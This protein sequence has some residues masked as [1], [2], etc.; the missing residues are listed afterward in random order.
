M[1]SIKIIVLLLLVGAARHSI[2]AQSTFRYDVK[3]GI[4]VLAGDTTQQV[5]LAGKR[6]ALIA[7]QSSR[8]RELQTSF[9]ILKGFS[10]CTV[11]SIMTPEH[12]FFGV[13]RAGEEV[14]DGMD[15]LAI[16]SY[17]LYGKNR[18]PTREMFESCDIVVYDLQ[19]IGVRS[20]TYLATLLNVMDACAEYGKP[21]IVLDRPNPLG[22][23][24]VDGNVLDT[25]VA[26]FVG[27]A[28]IPYLHG[29]TF[30]EIAQMANAEGWLKT[31]TDGTR[32]AC[33][34]TVIPMQGWQRWMTWEDTDF[35]WTPTSPHIPTVNAIRGA[36][37]LGVAGELS[38]MSI[39]I[40]YT[41]PFQMFGTPTFDAVKF[42][43]GI[44]KIPMN[45]IA[46]EETYFKPFYG[47][48]KDTVCH[49]FIM[50]FR[51]DVRFKPYSFGIEML[52][53]LRNLH[54]ELFTA[55][56]YPANTQSMFNKVTG[57]PEMFE[58]LFQKQG[59]DDEV[60]KLLQKGIREFMELRKKY[61]LYE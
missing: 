61:V 37:V 32:R 29:C 36:A 46:L 4:D 34:L 20:Y 18:R 45:G 1:K 52:L 23:R 12:G 15:S 11:A 33:S 10:F 2:Y 56:R 9:D 26:S 39:G 59:N 44:K 47:K 31:N 8:S 3:M 50:Q 53:V 7:N 6:V 14:D 42:Y 43:E 28:P 48:H 27:P 38:M 25:A 30:G 60:R 41:L 57:S 58:F 21:L 35:F 51:P 24:V 54:P 19:D 13:A 5:L 17:S 22:G 55:D 49:G 16:K 40:G